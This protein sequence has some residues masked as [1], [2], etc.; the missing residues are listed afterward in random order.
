M[1]DNYSSQNHDY[2]GCI[3]THVFIMHSYIASK[4]NIIDPPSNKQEI[5]RPNSS[6]NLLGVLLLEGALT[7]LSFSLG[8]GSHLLSFP[9]PAGPCREVTNIFKI[10]F[11]SPG[12]F[13]KVTRGMGPYS[14]HKVHITANNLYWMQKSMWCREAC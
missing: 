4:F 2:F 7:Y 6:S 12:S 5:P 10:S 3:I 11:H 1:Q 8:V 9:D 14:F 13:Q